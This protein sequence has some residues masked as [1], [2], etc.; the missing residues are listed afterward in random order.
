MF[1]DE[2]SRSVS[3]L[4]QKKLSFGCT[5]HAYQTGSR[6]P[7]IVPMVLREDGKQNESGFPDSFLLLCL[8]LTNSPKT[9]PT[10][11]C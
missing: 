8:S 11:S 1:S 3:Q 5:R 4:L 6:S 2:R 7:H 10:L 9:P